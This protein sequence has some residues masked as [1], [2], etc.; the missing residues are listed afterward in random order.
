MTSVETLLFK[1]WLSSNS[2]LTCNLALKSLALRSLRRVSF[3]YWRYFANDSIS[4]SRSSD[5]TKSLKVFNTNLRH[6]ERNVVLKLVRLRSWQLR[7]DILFRRHRWLCGLHFLL[8]RGRRLCFELLLRTWF[9]AFTH[10]IFKLEG[11]PRATIL[12]RFLRRSNWT[13][14]PITSLI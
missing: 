10:L 4:T 9:I 13:K 5:Y 7:L 3:A 2:C 1:S 8:G 14:S 6:P 12:D 11:H